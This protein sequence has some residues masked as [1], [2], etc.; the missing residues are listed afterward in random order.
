M[1]QPEFTPVE[2][3]GYEV[4][5]AGNPLALDNGQFTDITKNQNKMQI[6]KSPSKIMKGI[7]YFIVICFR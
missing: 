3:V 5:E 4:Y 2:I 6:I 1:V 7:T